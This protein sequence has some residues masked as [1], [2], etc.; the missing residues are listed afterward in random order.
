M[1]EG[2]ISKYDLLQLFN[3]EL[4]GGS[5]EVVPDAGLQLDKA[6][7]RTNFNPIYRPKPYLEQVR[8]MAG[9]VRAHKELYPHYE[10]I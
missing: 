1:P 2:S 3:R 6:L 9:W 7:M 4:R 10:V 5:V 8:E